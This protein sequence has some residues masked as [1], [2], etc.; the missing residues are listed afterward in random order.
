MIK[1]NNITK[2]LFLCAFFSLI[3]FTKLTFSETKYDYDTQLK[4]INALLAEYK[5]NLEVW[6]A[7]RSDVQ[8]ILQYY[9]TTKRRCKAIARKY[10][11]TDRINSQTCRYL[12]RQ[13]IKT[14]MERN[15]ID[16]ILNLVQN[17]Q[18]RVRVQ[19]ESKREFMA[20]NSHQ[21]K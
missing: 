10:P 8:A 20:E 11:Q 5:G 16:N 19:E 13:V 21:N 9:N 7:I 3:G 1:I 15:S 2:G 4:Q 6:N 14:S 12:E 18:R 17:S